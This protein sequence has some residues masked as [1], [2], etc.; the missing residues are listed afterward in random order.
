FGD[1]LGA[2]L[3]AIAFDA[4]DGAVGPALSQHRGKRF[5]L[6]GRLG[7]SHWGGRQKAELRLED[8]APAG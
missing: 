8:A 5:H 7:I 4:F 6:V 3:E 1:G 2:R